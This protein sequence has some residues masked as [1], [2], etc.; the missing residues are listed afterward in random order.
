LN[1]AMSRWT[2]AAGSWPCFSPFSTQNLKRHPTW[3]LC[4]SKNWK[5]FILGDFEV[6]R[7]NLENVAKVPEDIQGHYSLGRVWPWLWPRVGHTRVS[8]WSMES[9]GLVGEV[10][11]VMTQVDLGLTNVSRFD[12][13]DSVISV[14]DAT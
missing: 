10:F 1:A 2:G 4:I 6:F 14:N 5:T 3:K 12:S 13:A 8:T 7:W 11:E 9:L